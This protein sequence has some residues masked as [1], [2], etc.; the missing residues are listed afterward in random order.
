M[1]SERSPACKDLAERARKSYREQ[2]GSDPDILAR[3]PGRLELLG[4]H[5]DYNNG[6]ILSVALELAVV[7]AAG[8]D[9]TSPCGLAGWSSE[10]NE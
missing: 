2:F 1:M 5:T 10:L 9:E 4:N 7:L 6:Y 3:A 8:K